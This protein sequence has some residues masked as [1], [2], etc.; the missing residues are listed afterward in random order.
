MVF[1]ICWYLLIFVVDLCWCLLMFLMFVDI[2][3]YLVIF[4]DRLG[5]NVELE[6]KSLIQPKNIAKWNTFNALTWIKTGILIKKHL[7]T[8]H[9]KNVFFT[10]QT[11]PNTNKKQTATTKKKSNNKTNQTSTKPKIKQLH[12]LNYYTLCTLFN[13][14]IIFIVC[15]H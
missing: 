1:D 8:V 9:R 15:H 14:F 4:F 10:K 12:I 5:M 11:K 7:I 6:K 2:C 13:I 3:W